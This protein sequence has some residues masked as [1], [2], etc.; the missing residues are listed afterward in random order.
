MSD[1]TPQGSDPYE[2]HQRLAQVNAKL[3]H[4]GKDQR[5][6]AQNYSFRGIDDIFDAVH[7]LLAEEE[8]YIS[9]EVIDYE[10]NPLAK[11]TRWI[12]RIRYW[13]VA[14]NGSRTSCTVIGEAIDYQDKGMNKAMQQA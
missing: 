11:G 8:V 13:F 14:D 3:T 9:P 5:N 12:V 6:Q 7:P 2:I 4:V 10:C 1:P